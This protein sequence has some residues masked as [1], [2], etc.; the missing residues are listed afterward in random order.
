MVIFN[1][2]SGQFLGHILRVQ[3]LEPFRNYHY[4]LPYNLEE[5]ISQDPNWNANSSPA[6]KEIFALTLQNQR[7]PLMFTWVGHYSRLSC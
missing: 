7:I 6:S 5:R 3:D 4:P 2:V 1:D